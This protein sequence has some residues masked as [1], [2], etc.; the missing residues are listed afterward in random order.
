MLAS[1]MRALEAGHEWDGDM[2]DVTLEDVEDLRSR[3]DFGDEAI[4][5]SVNAGKSYRPADAKPV[6]GNYSVS[7]VTVPAA[8]SSS[9]QQR[10]QS[11][12]RS[13]SKSPS[14]SSD[15]KSANGNASQL[16][17][18]EEPDFELQRM[19]NELEEELSKEFKQK[20]SISTKKFG[21]SPT[22]PSTSTSSPQSNQVCRFWLQG[23]CRR[24][25]GCWYRHDQQ[26][27]NNGMP[28]QM[29]PL[30]PVPMVPP[31]MP[32]HMQPPPP[33]VHMPPPFP[34]GV[35]HPHMPMHMPPPPHAQVMT[36]PMMSIHS[37][38]STISSTSSAPSNGSSDQICRFFLQ[39]NCRR[40]DQCWYKHAYPSS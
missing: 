40:G 10:H 15:K 36:P 21:Q 31:H 27:P 4:K 16:K 32:P 2:E 6:T 5:F 37:N 28:E 35:P 12:K 25:A 30:P 14:R 33:G 17:S 38:T 9:Q 7:G 19:E 11:P 18:P 8:G 22:S 1:A 24:G 23:S 13:T 39:G 34:M 26:A 20:S 29:M 3:I